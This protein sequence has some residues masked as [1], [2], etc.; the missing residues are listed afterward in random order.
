MY[1][2]LTIHN[3]DKILTIKNPH[4][5][6]MDIIKNENEYILNIDT[7]PLYYNAP[8]NKT[9]III[10]R[11][12][13]LGRYRIGIEGISSHTFSTDFIDTI[14]RMGLVIETLLN[15]VY[16]KNSISK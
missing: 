14:P 6:V 16:L 2:R 7:H 15:N 3:I 8:Q 4:Y 5:I 10:N 13:E 11:I 9:C 12:K 1:K